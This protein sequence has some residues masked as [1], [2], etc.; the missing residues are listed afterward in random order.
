MTTYLGLSAGE[1]TAILSHPIYTRDDSK[2]C[3]NILMRLQGWVSAE[4]H[5][6]QTNF[7]SDSNQ[8]QFLRISRST[9]HPML[10]T[11]PSVQVGCRVDKDG[12]INCQLLAFNSITIK[13]LVASLDEEYEDLKL[14]LGKL[15]SHQTSICKGIPEEKLVTWAIRKNLSQIL[16]E[17]FLTRVVF[18]ERS[19][20]YV[21]FESDQADIC[22]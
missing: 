5:N 3:L 1:G 4:F 17:R 13:E 19:C 21:M 10:V 22:R 12:L 15:N 6:L 18:R 14:L 16:I 20:S 7:L 8:E 9:P 2:I 11:Q